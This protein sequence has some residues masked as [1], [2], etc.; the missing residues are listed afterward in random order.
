MSEEQIYFNKQEALR[1]F[2]AR[3]GDEQAEAAVDAAYQKLKNELQPR[4]TAKRFGCRVI[5]ENGISYVQLD[6][7]TRF[8]GNALARYVGDARALYVFGA[9]L[10]SRVDTALRRM[11]I[12]SV[13]EAGAGQATAT[14]LI[15]TY[16]DDCCRMLQKKLPEGQRLKWRFSPGYGDWPLEEQRILFSVLDCAHTIGLTLTKSCMMAPVKSVTAVIAILNRK[17]PA[18]VNG[19][20]NPDPPLNIKEDG[21]NLADSEGCGETERVSLSENKCLRCGK[22]NCEFRRTVPANDATDRS[23][24]T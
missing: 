24:F 21:K 17:E 10:G 16:C 11:A 18:A 13:A 19:V 5:E 7:G 22:I 23:E 15:E 9:T 3:Q 8:Q 6:N 20:R 2:R 1:Y 4:F 14:A 12:T